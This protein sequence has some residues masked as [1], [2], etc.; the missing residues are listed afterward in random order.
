MAKKEDQ[1]AAPEKTD[2]PAAAEAGEK[3][4]KGER[5]EKAQRADK[6]ES[7]EAAEKAPKGDKPAKGDKAPKA[8]KAAK[9]HKPAKAEKSEQSSAPGRK[10]RGRPMRGKS[11]RHKTNSA[12]VTRDKKYELGEAVKLLKDVTGGTKFDQT[13]NIV[14]HLG[15]DPKHAEQMIRGSVSLPRGIG[16]T[17]KVI[18]FVDAEEADQA[19]AAGAI[20]VGVDDLI[21]KVNDG[22]TDF[23]VAIAHP[24]TMGKVGR[25]GRVLGPQGKMPSPKN[26]T[27]TADIANAV[28]EFAAGK[29]EFRNDAGANVHAI[30]GKASFSADDL[31]EN[32]NSFIGHI[33]RMKPATSKGQYIKKV[34]ISGTMS[35]AIELDVQQ[36]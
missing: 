1:A 29:I 6:T 8:E 17:K 27:V 25:L 23:D 15:I 19:R 11:R 26:G 12:K 9:A 7:P 32:I 13:I 18:A 16:K 24:R 20:E 28:K 10:N 2:Q 14:M 5:P 35:P 22:W 33:R 31:K 34:C 21:K 36:A 30:V 3:R 4:G